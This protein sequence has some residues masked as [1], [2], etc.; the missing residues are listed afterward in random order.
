MVRKFLG[1]PV[2]GIEHGRGA[3]SPRDSSVRFTLKPPRA[4]R[5]RSGFE[6]RLVFHRKTRSR[7]HSV[8]WLCFAVRLFALLEPFLNNN[9]G[10]IDNSHA[11]S[12]WWFFPKSYARIACKRQPCA[13]RTLPL[14]ACTK[15]K[16]SLPIHFRRRGGGRRRKEN[17]RKMQG[18]FLVFAHA[19]P[20]ACPRRIGSHHHAIGAYEAVSSHH[21]LRA[22]VSHQNPADFARTMFELRPKNT[23]LHNRAAIGNQRLTR[24]I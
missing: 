24:E 7:T 21:A 13:P 19:S 8:R 14:V 20:R 1:L 11:P 16:I 18:N 6:R 10:A 2:R 9:R 15:P 3:E 4:P 17:A 5:V 12:A 23:A 22:C